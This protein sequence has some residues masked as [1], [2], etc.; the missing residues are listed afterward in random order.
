MLLLGAAHSFIALYCRKLNEE[1]LWFLGA[2]IAIIL[3]G[4]INVIDLTVSNRLVK[5]IVLFV[6]V[7]MTA[8]FC[9]AL[10]AVGDVQVYMGISLFAAA[11]I[12]RVLRHST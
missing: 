5:T 7:L 11:S 8:L 2:G 12:S 6:N 1:T 10:V 9:L 3:A 4:L